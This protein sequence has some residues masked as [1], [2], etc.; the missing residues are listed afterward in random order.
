MKALVLAGGTATRLRP[1]S[2]RM[3]KQLIPIANRPVL[4][5]V[6]DSIAAAGVSEVGMVVGDWAPQIQAAIGDG[7]RFGLEI[8]Y[9]RQDLPLGLA[10]CVRLARGFTGDDDFLMYLGDNVLPDGIADLAAS[11]ARSRPAA[12]VT[13][14]RVPDPRAFGVVELDRRGGVRR[15]VEKP[16]RPRS[17][18]AVI[19][20]YFF[21]AAVHAAVAAIEPS[22]RGELEITDAIQ[23][24]LASG[25]PVRAVEYHGYWKDTGTIDDVLACNR[26]LLQRLPYA[27]TGD[28]DAAS[29]VG[30]QVVVE[31]GARI[32]DSQLEGPS[33]IGADALVVASRIGPYTSVGDGCR[34]RDSELAD[35][36]VMSGAP[37]LAGARLDGTVVGPAA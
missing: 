7:T 15:L 22:G 31:A 23:W 10:H 25:A 37:A 1:L 16:Q 9:L 8:A 5:H 4:E 35:S 18:L 28:V 6:L 12:Q 26:A 14:Y 2:Q 19:G 24:L 32:V 27:V 33:I 36:I 13:T 17:D 3:P 21:T 34:L 11:F 30:A 20:V 29:K